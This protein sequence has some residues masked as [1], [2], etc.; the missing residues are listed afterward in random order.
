MTTLAVIVSVILGVLSVGAIV[1]ATFGLYVAT[2]LGVLVAI[3]TLIVLSQ[4]LGALLGD[5]LAVLAR[6]VRR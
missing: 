5:G 2:A 6:A 3:V 1:L 4:Y